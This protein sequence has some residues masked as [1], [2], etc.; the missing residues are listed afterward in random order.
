M[1]GYIEKEYNELEYDNLF[2][3]WYEI[4]GLANIREL[5]RQLRTFF[6]YK[7]EII[8]LRFRTSVKS[9]ADNPNTPFYNQKQEIEALT[10]DFINLLKQIKEGNVSLEEAL[11][12][13]VFEC[14]KKQLNY[15]LEVTGNLSR[16]LHQFSENSLHI[17]PKFLK[18]IIVLAKNISFVKKCLYVKFSEFYEELETNYDGLGK[19]LESILENVP[20]VKINKLK[21]QYEEGLPS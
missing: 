3:E 21:K 1:T 18:F 14:T 11:H 17:Y 4:E 7:T 19:E 2:Y 6:N 16:F 8:R 12:S 13:L 15:L 10:N 5:S 9:S 20:R